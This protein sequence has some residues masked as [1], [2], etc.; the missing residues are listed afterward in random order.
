VE[1]RKQGFQLFQCM[2][3]LGFITQG[4]RRLLE[5]LGIKGIPAEQKSL[6]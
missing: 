4:A 1:H 3:E 5:P 6:Y 2:T